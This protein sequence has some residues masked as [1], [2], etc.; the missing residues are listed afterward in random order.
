[1]TPYRT[2]LTPILQDGIS[3]LKKIQSC[4][5]AFQYLLILYLRALTDPLESIK[6]A[7]PT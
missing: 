7:L 1:M 2:N 5:P 3:T 6:W 4:S